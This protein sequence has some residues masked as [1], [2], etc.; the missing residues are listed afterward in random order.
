MIEYRIPLIEEIREEIR[1]EENL[2]KD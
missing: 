1:K 2:D